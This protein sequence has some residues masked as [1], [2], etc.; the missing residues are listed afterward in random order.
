M[1]KVTPEQLEKRKRL[2]NKIKKFGCL[3]L[4]I[5]FVIIMLLPKS[6]EKVIDMKEVVYNNATTSG[7]KNWKIEKYSD[8]DLGDSWNFTPNQKIE[9]DASTFTKLFGLEDKAPDIND[10]F[11]AQWL[12]NNN[13]EVRV[14]KD[15]NGNIRYAVAMKMNQKAVANNEILK[16]FEKQ[17]VSVGGR[18]IP[19]SDAVKQQLKNPDSF[20]NV[21]T[22]YH[23]NN[24]G[25]I[26]V[27]MTFSAKNGFNAREEYLAKATVSPQG[28]VLSLKIE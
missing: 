28:E 3:P 8:S 27:K 21:Q 4:F 6:V 17:Y 19:V 18:V 20:I 14:F 9:F 11:S 10:D 22:N 13:M 26:F 1:K 24:K 2:T 15:K 16:K 23:L 12:N 7:A 25:N 5:L